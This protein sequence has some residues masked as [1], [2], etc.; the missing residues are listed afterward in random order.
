MKQNP[1]TSRPRAPRQ[2]PTPRT[3]LKI[4]LTIAITVFSVV[5]APDT[6]DEA[7]ADLTEDERYLV[8][9]YVQLAYARDTHYVNALKSESL[10]AAVD[11]TIDSLRIANTIR[12]VNE[13]P[14]RWILIFESIERELTS[15]QG[16]D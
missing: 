4:A 7:L 10:F 14:D 1:Q 5:C 2:A 12:T 11:S 3:V 8:S 6:D 9:V 16:G 13:E 15:F